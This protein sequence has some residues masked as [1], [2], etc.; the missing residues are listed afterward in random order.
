MNGIVLAG[1]IGGTKSFLG[2]FAAEGSHLRP[3][4]EERYASE[5]FDG[6]G[7]MVLAFLAGGREAIDA[8]CF[9]IAGPII[10]DH[11][12]PLNLPWRIDRRELAEEIGVERTSMVNDF[13]AVG[14]GLD[15]LTPA[16]LAVLQEGRPVPRGVIA[17]AGAGT[18]LGE[19]FLTWEEDRYHVHASEGGHTDFAPQ[20]RLE[21][22]LF[23]FLARKYGHVSYERVLSGHGLQSIYEYLIESGAAPA[24]IP[25]HER[26]LHDDPAAVITTQAL[27]GTD[28]ASVQAL[29]LFASVYGAEA[30][31]LALKVLAS[32]GVYLAGGIAPKILPKLH[33][34]TFLRAFL[35]KGRH[36]AFLVNVPVRVIVNAKVGLLGAAACAAGLPPRGGLSA[37]G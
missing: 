19:G 28:A 7:P 29:D 33:D 4:R 10:G 18:G 14:L 8:A 6:L 2:L 36:A 9:G 11:A 13:H 12:R 5:S 27:A 1:D 34:G 35:D 17:V 23:E 26:M 31:N 37:A 15:H 32:G 30:G 3:L 21:F 16:D 22:G 24:S 20:S 25:V